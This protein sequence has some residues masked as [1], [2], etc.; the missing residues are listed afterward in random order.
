LGGIPFPEGYCHYI[1]GGAGGSFSND[2][3]YLN[4][5]AFDFSIGS[6]CG[7]SSARGR[8]CWG[9]VTWQLNLA[10]NIKWSVDVQQKKRRRNNPLRKC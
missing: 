10:V 9:L 4:E 2:C 3:A 7:F 1:E 6:L 5:N 8:L